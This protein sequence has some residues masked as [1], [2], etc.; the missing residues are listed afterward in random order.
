[1]TAYACRMTPTGRPRARRGCALAA[2]VMILLLLAA[3][4]LTSAG[5]AHHARSGEAASA[6][7]VHDAAG[8]RLAD[9]HEHKHGNDWTPTPGKRLRP[10]AAVTI[11]GVA[12]ARPGTAGPARGATVPPATALPGLVLTALSVLRV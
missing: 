4:L 10:A 6:A 1:M 5:S 8:L 2:T 7:T 11:L 12:A 9:Q 3:S